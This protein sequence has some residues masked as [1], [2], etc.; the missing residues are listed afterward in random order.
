MN[1]LLLF[2]STCSSKTQGRPVKPVMNSKIPQCLLHFYTIRKKVGQKNLE[3][4][5]QKSKKLKKDSK[6]LT[7]LVF[8]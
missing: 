7:P 4:K 8:I 5:T 1:G 3:L 2:S 6:R